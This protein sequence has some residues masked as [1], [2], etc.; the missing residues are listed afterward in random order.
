MEWAVLGTGTIANEMAAALAKHGKHFYAAAGRTHDK[1]VAFAEKYGVEKVYDQIDELFEDP[2]TDVIYIATP[3]NTHADYIRKAVEHGKHVLAEKAITLNSRELDEVMRL[4]EEKNVIV[5]EAMT[6]YHMP[7]YRKLRE[8]L[9]SGRLG[10]VNLITVN[11]GSFKEYDMENRFF[12]KKLAGGAL[13]DI[14]VYALAFIRFFMDEKPNQLLSRM[15]PAPT[16]TDEQAGLLLMN[17]C[18]QMASAMLSFRSKQPKRGM[19]SCEKG[20]I[21]IMDYPRAVEAAITYT[22]TGETEMVRAGAKESAL[23]CEFEDM[24]VAVSGQP[25]RM[26]TGYTEDVMDMMTKFRQQW[27]LVYPEEIFTKE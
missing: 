10:R 11:F 17:D 5:A 12:N 27:G 9:D 14:G 19:V 25:D 7:L 18:G 8:M 13:L 16:G 2:K 23:F 24:E 15:K 20:Y 6:I 21:E 4:A 26:L 3:H 1:A 22:E